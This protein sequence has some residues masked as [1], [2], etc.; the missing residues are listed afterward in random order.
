MHAYF[1][2]LSDAWEASLLKRDLY[3]RLAQLK[4]RL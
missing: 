1:E 3:D 4:K 2:D